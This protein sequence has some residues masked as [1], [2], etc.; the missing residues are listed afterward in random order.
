MMLAHLNSILFLLVYIDFK[1]LKLYLV[2]YVTNNALL[3]PESYL[4]W[5]KFVT[6]KTPYINEMVC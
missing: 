2:I 4:H 5:S 6:A 3:C 1:D